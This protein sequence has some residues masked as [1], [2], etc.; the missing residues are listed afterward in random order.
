LVEDGSKVI[1]K[2]DR[3][4]QLVKGQDNEF[5]KIGLAY[6]VQK[7]ASDGFF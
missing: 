6:M 7:F 4:V 2:V 3:V 5:I 1:G